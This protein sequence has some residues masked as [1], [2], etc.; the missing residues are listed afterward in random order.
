MRLQGIKHLHDLWRRS[1]VQRD[2]S[3]PFQIFHGNDLFPGKRG[4]FFDAAG[5]VYDA[6][7]T[8]FLRQPVSVSEALKSP[9]LRL[10]EFLG[11]QADKMMTA[12][13]NEA[14]QDL[15]KAITSGK[16]PPQD[17]KQ[18]QGVNGSMLLMGGPLAGSFV[19]TGTLM[20]ALV[21]LGFVIFA[22][23]LTHSRG[24]VILAFL[25]MFFILAYYVDPLY[26]MLS[27]LKDYLGYRR[28]YTYTFDGND[29]LAD[30]NQAV[31]DL[32]AAVSTYNNNVNPPFQVGK[33]YMFLLYPNQEKN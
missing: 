15:G 23:E 20:M 8:D 25:L 18:N 22:W 32:N 3:F 1:S 9:F 29:Q 19:V 28:R 17:A 10:G 11:K 24:A 30:L 21:Y 13:S 5:D 31:T 6:K 12:K 7:I 16:L 27:S 2:D 4:V 26:Q 33:Q 14:Q